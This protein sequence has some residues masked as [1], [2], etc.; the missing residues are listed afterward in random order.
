MSAPARGTLNG[1]RLSD[2]EAFRQGMRQL[3]AE[4]RAAAPDTAA[5]Q[6]ALRQIAV[7]YPEE[8]E[9]LQIHTAATPTGDWPT[10]APRWEALLVRL[11]AQHA[12]D[13]AE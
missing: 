13:W 1:S 3:R 7:R 12:A 8:A 4:L 9:E 5:V 11:E 6:R 2:D 10:Q